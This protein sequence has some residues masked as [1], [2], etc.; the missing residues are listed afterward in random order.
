[1]HALPSG[2]VRGGKLSVIGSG[3]VLDPWHLVKE[4]ATVAEQGIEITPEN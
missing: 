2:V 3:V 1:L 4:I